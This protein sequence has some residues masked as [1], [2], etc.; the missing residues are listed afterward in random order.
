MI[1]L[2]QIKCFLMGAFLTWIIL[3]NFNQ[4]GRIKCY[5]IKEYRLKS[6]LAPFVGMTTTPTMKTLDLTSAQSA[7]RSRHQASQSLLMLR[8]PRWRVA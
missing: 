3:K 2:I 4:Y 5:E 6:Y 1:E 8:F 7:R